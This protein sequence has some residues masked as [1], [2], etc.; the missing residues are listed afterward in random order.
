MRERADV[1][2]SAYGVAQDVG[3]KAI[4]AGSVVVP[5][6]ADHAGYVMLFSAFILLPAVSFTPKFLEQV[7]RSR[8]G[9]NNEIN[10]K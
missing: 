3:D 10:N 5:F 8:E 7:R 2:L 6:I 4:G 1:L 9:N